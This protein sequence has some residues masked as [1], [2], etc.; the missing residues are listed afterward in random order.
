MAWS[1][2]GMFAVVCVDF[3]EHCSAAGSTRHRIA[4][5]VRAAEATRNQL[6]CCLACLLMRPMF[7]A[8]LGQR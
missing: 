1:G 6:E 8:V 5:H 2:P 4:R 3:C 7:G